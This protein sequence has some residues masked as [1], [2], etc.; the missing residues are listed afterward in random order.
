MYWLKNSRSK[1]VKIKKVS[2]VPKSQSQHVRAR[3]LRILAQRNGEQLL[4]EELQSMTRKSKVH[5]HRWQQLIYKMY[6]R[7]ETKSY[8]I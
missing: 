5:M 2:T 1:V 4:Q 6:S 8:L 7:I 3:L